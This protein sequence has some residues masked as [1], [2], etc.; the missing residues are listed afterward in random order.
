MVIV[1]HGNTEGGAN[2]LP[3]FDSTVYSHFIV[4]GPLALLHSH[5]AISKRKPIL[6]IKIIFLI[7]YKLEKYAIYVLYITKKYYRKGHSSN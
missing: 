5:L 2:M 6:N 3:A 7:I 4:L 1:A